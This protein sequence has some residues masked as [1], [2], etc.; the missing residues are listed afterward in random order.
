[1]AILPS[2]VRSNPNAS[3]L[4]AG[5][6]AGGVAYGIFEQDP[7]TSVAIGAGATLITRGLIHL[8]TTTHTIEV[9]KSKVVIAE[10]GDDR[11]A[12]SGVLDLKELEAMDLSEVQQQV[13][14]KVAKKATKAA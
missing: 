3:S 10:I 5:G 14:K 2:I 8:G 12:F 11:F 13:A 7:L 9:G 6:L 4:V 1:M